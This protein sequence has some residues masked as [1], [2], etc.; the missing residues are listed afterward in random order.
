[1]VTPEIAAAH[2]N[3]VSAQALTLPTYPMPNTAVLGDQNYGMNLFADAEVV[4][5]SIGAPGQLDFYSFA[6]TAG[7]IINAEVIS[8]VPN[9]YGETTGPSNVD[10]TITLLMPNGVSQVPGP[11]FNDDEFESFDAALIDVVLPVTGTYYVRIG[12]TSFIPN[13]TGNYELFLFRF[14]ATPVPE[15]ASLT[16]LALASFLSAGSLRRRGP[17]CLSGW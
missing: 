12:V 3:A 7:D 14:R 2:G 1:M 13:D 17:S 15:P 11:S 4:T 10:A 9:R 16:L 6:G 5:A 8:L